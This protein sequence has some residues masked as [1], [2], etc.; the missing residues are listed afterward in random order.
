M[1]PVVRKLKSRVR[2]SI[3]SLGFHCDTPMLVIESDDW[4]SIRVPSV[5]V[6]WDYQRQFPDHVLNHYQVFDALDT[7]QDLESLGSLLRC[8]VDQYDRHPV[9]TMNYSMANPVFDD[10][11]STLG[12]PFRFEPIWETF[13]RE[14]GEQSSLAAMR[15]NAYRDVFTPQLHGREHLNVTAWRHGIE[16]AENL[17]CAYQMRMIGLDPGPFSALDALNRNNRE[18]SL[19]DYL[20]DACRL[21]ADCFGYEPESFIPPCYVINHVEERRLF[22]MGITVLQSGAKINRSLQNGRLV[23]VPTPMGSRAA[24]GQVRLVRNV[25]FEPSRWLFEGKSAEDLIEGSF[26]EIKRAID[27]RQPAIVCS[28]RV[29]YV[30]GMSVQNRESSLECLNRLLKK[31]LDA[32]PTISFLSSDELGKLI[33]SER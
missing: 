21:F 18:I 2:Q 19:Y 14:Q 25:Q 9:F 15:S 33:L 3:N 26:L 28:H 32:Y 1:I 11:N 23:G 31:V 6:L 16:K 5:D 7:A 13:L 17:R 30:G 29:N 20:L 4:G 12:E 22:E 10:D 8:F 27:L 24:R